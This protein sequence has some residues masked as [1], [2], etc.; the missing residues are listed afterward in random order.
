MIFRTLAAISLAMALVQAPA[1]TAAQTED[2]APVSAQNPAATRPAPRPTA[3]QTTVPRSSALPAQNPAPDQGSTTSPQTGQPAPNPSDNTN[4]PGGNCDEWPSSVKSVNQPPAPPFW[5]LHERIL[6]AAL[7]VLVVFGYI[8]I[9]IAIS[10]LKKIERNTKS[11]EEAAAAAYDSARAALVH[12]EAIVKAER[13]WILVAI[14]PSPG[15]ANGF[16]V[17]AANRGRTP[18]R[19]VAVP[20]KIEFAEEESSLP[21]VPQYPEASSAAPFVPIV[22]LPG[23]F[24]QLASFCRDDVKELCTSDEQYRRVENW[25][26]KIF[27]YGRV[28]YRDLLSPQDEQIHQ[29]AWCFWYI[30]GHQ[31]SGMVPAGSRNYNMH[32]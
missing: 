12:A 8:G 31:N 30:H 24:T 23:E 29:S 9:M 16:T 27:L 4:C 20:H 17:T 7:L 25:E 28:T 22:L 5:P 19:I 3:P 10:T 18:A 15:V 11:G 6:W 13:P 14:E 26:E 21:D 2:S 1:G 32:T